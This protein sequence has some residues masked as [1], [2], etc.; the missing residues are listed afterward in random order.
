MAKLENVDGPTVCVRAK[1]SITDLTS[2]YTHSEGRTFIVI[3]GSAGSITYRAF[4]DDEDQTEAGLDAGDMIACGAFPVG[5]IAVRSSST[6]TS[7]V[8]GVIS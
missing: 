6:V 7:I 3:A 5:I 4:G 8:I 1:R 2:D